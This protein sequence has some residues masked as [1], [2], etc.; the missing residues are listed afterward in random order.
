MSL[1]AQSA[2]QTDL[3]AINGKVSPLKYG[4]LKMPPMY[5]LWM[6]QES[7]KQ[8]DHRFIMYLASQTK[9]LMV[10]QYL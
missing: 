8:I 7:I 2:K 5:G 4:E 9:M 10:C 1:L 6:E 3:D